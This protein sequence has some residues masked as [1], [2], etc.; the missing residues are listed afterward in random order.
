MRT[1]KSIK[2]AIIAVIA[3]IVTMIVG[4]VSQAIF[5][6]G[7]GKEYLGVNSLFSNIIYMLSIVEL[8]VGTAIIYNLYKP[9]AE[10][11]VEKIKS[12]LQFY[13]K[14]YKIIAVTILIISIILS[15]V[16]KNIVGDVQITENVYIV[17]ALFVIDTVF[18]YLITYKRSILYATQ[19]TY[20]VNIIHIGYIIC[21]NVVASVIII[22]LGNYYIYLISKIL[23]R[24]LENVIVN[25]IAE[26][27]YPYINE[28]DNIQELDKET[29]KEIIKKIKALFFHKIG[30]VMLLGTDSI[31]VSKFLGIVWVGLYSNYN[32]IVN[33]IS[34]I[35]GQV[36]SAVTASVGNLLV[37]ENTEKIYVVY[38]RMILLNFWLVSFC[39]VSIFC[40][41]K[42]FIILWIGSD[43]LLSE[44]TVF[45]IVIVFYMQNMKKTLKVFKEAAGKFEKD[46][47]IPIIESLVNIL[48]SIFFVKHLGL[49]GV[50][51]GTF[52]STLVLYCYS[53]PKIVYKQIFKK[54][55]KTYT[56]EYIGYFA[57]MLMAF[58]ISY[59]MI[60]VFKFDNNFI[61]LLV[62]FIVCLIVPNIIY[63]MIY[64]NTKEFEFY[65]LLV[66][67][68]IERR[69]ND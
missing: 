10:N 21:M 37:E 42:P 52:L 4:V 39:T 20:I 35:F 29:L 6:K 41:I 25:L 58:A 2:N 27:K 67:R 1:D 15:L 32:M 23:F 26:K 61:Q 16:L 7:F 46:K 68:T 47:Y 53:F 49:I 31:I 38:K 45:V 34:G 51:I 12:L 9:V 57:I 14:A 3:N 17:F 33:A 8:G 60:S 24:I 56:I 19:N 69:K 43:Y 55:Y 22:L 48:C 54:D 59:T 5:V 66:K 65:K 63:F 40:M 44:M 18:S 50:F 28:K 62:N 30:E 13:K 11:D 36:F 64:H